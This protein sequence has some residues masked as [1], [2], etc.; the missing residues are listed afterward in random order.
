MSHPRLCMTR[1]ASS[2]WRARAAVGDAEDCAPQDHH[3]AQEL[4][5]LWAKSKIAF[6][7][8]SGDSANR[9]SLFELQQWHCRWPIS[10][11]GA[12]DFGFCGN[13]NG[14]R[15]ALL[16]VH[17]RMAYR[18]GRRGPQPDRQRLPSRMKVSIGPFPLISTVPCGSSRKRSWMCQWVAAEIWMQFGMPCNSMRL[19]MFTASPQM[20]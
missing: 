20:S 14:R 15:P 13:K 3:P 6:G 1:G 17:A 9:C 11:P 16:R 5:A 12:E 7:E 8:A 18:P 10:E 2:P 19:A 4:R